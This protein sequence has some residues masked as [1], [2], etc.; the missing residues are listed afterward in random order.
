[1]SGNLHLLGL[2]IHSGDLWWI[3]LLG[4]F[5]GGSILE[6]IGDKLG[7][8]LRAIQGHREERR[9]H[10]LERLRLLAQLARDIREP[11]GVPSRTVAGPCKHPRP[12]PVRDTDGILV[13]W[14]CSNP[15]CEE[16]LP[17]DFAV[18]ADNA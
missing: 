10:E 1:M 16:Q 6:W 4:F 7:F 14:L 8:G 2:T 3:I 11:P 18:L 15:D 12:L 5:F 17:K 9:E 13:S